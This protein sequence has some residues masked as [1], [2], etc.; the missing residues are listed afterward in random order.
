MIKAVVFVP[1]RSNDGRTFPRE[2]WQELV[3]RC[4]QFGGVTRAGVVTGVWFSGGQRYRDRN[5]P[6]VV[7]LTSWTQLPA[8]LAVVA[9]IQER[10]GQEAM[11]IEVQGT[12]EIIDFRSQGS[13]ARDL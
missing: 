10:F 5:W 8:W 6:Y 4:A 13:A 3:A 7:A 11:Y 12:P 9:W 1:I 2:S